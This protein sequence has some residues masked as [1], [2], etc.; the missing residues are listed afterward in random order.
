MPAIWAIPC[1]RA[2][3]SPSP[4][5]SIWPTLCSNIVGVLITAQQ[6]RRRAPGGISRCEH[7]P[8]SCPGSASSSP[9]PVRAAQQLMAIEI[10][11]RLTHENSDMD[12]SDSDSQGDADDAASLQ[13]DASDTSSE[14]TQLD[15]ADFPG[16]FR[17]RHGRLFHSHGGSPYPLPVDAEE[18]EVRAP[19]ATPAAAALTLT[20]ATQRVNGQ[21]A[22]LFRLL[23]SNFR[24][25]VRHAVRVQ[26]RVL[27]LCTGTGQWCVRAEFDRSSRPR[28]L[29]NLGRVLDMAR[30]FPNVRFD[31]IDIGAS[32]PRVRR[33]AGPSRRARAPAQCPSPHASRPTTCTSR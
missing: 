19:P 22:L 31:G 32:L 18:Q 10:A 12:T 16:Y 26:K 14:V 23:G 24:G 17:E 13:S 28:R 3:I 20:P 25:P 21:H 7:P 5:R 11:P 8:S 27:D 2:W 33:A 15:H 9:L 4:R 30:D 1:D 29:L 6:A